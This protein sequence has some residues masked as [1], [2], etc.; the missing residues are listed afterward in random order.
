MDLGNRVMRAAVR[1]EPYEHGL[2]SASKIG[3]STAFRLAWT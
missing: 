3:S 1:A 2:K